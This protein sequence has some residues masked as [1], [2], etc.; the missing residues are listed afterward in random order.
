MA[1]KKR[2][3]VHKSKP[4]SRARAK[5]A[6]PEEM[7]SP[8]EKY[9]QFSD[10]QPDQRQADWLSKG[11]LQSAQRQDLARQ[12]GQVQGNQHLQRLAAPQ[13]ERPAPVESS[14]VQLQRGQ[15]RR[16]ANPG[17]R[18]PGGIQHASEVYYNVT[19]STLDQVSNQLDHFD[20]FAAQTSAPLGIRGRVRPE[21]QEDGSYRA[22]VQWVIN[23]AQVHLPRW[24]G[25]DHA[26][27]AAQSEWD[28][29]MTQARLHEQEAHVDAARDFVSN[30]GEEDTVIT[31]TT[32][33]ELQT[34][35]Q[36]KQIELAERL[37]A[38]HD[39]C[40]HGASIDA[41]L[42]PENGTCEE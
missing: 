19:G 15:R 1:K 18:G 24:T 27:Q 3:S 30:L 7:R 42:H 9:P 35:L 21:R 17:G 10:H 32:L 29:F 2:V 5:R 23:G 22:Q 20:G 26:C 40:D 31:G 8:D 11:N 37:Q 28:R 33:A 14:Q 25:Y 34:N 12:I 36:A 41:Y 4:K 16:G 6:L 39:A 13:N 38:I